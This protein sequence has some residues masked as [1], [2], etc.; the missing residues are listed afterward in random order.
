M[1]WIDYVYRADE[2]LHDFYA[3]CVLSVLDAPPDD[4]GRV[5]VRKTYTFKHETQVYYETRMLY[6]IERY[7]E[8]K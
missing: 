3:N 6:D 7:W 8:R 1:N 5:L 2:Y 4:N